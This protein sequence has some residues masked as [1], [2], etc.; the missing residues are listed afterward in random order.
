MLPLLHTSG[1]NNR[2]PCECTREPDNGEYLLKGGLAEVSAERPAYLFLMCPLSI[3]FVLYRVSALPIQRVL[4]KL[5]QIQMQ[6]L[7][8]LFPA[9]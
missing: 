5:I 4:F 2:A 9:W 7:H 6:I 3:C 8:L 1:S